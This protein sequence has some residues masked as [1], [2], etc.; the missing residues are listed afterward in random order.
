MGE[1]VPA[2]TTRGGNRRA[3]MQIKPKRSFSSSFVAAFASVSCLIG[4]DRQIKM[5][6]RCNLLLLALARMESIRVCA[7]AEVVSLLPSGKDES[8]QNPTIFSIAFVAP[9]GF[10]QNNKQNSERVFLV[11]NGVESSANNPLNPAKSLHI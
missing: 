10:S 8:E 4:M 3:C 5:V 1:T 9:V 11:T 7:P 2:A 6:R